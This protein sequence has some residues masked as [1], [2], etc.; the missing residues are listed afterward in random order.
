VL[1]LGGVLVKTA[2]IPE[3]KQA[4]G[5]LRSVSIARKAL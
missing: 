4:S 3:K 5:F 2:L 1:T